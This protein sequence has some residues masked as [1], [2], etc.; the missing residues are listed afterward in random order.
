MTDF[1]I[2]LSTDETDLDVCLSKPTKEVAK[3]LRGM[4][5]KSVID[6]DTDHVLRVVYESAKAAIDEISADRFSTKAGNLLFIVI[7]VSA[8]R[9]IKDESRD[10]M[11]DAIEKEEAVE[12]HC[13]LDSKENQVTWRLY[14]AES[15]H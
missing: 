5:P 3:I 14:G 15:L 13:L 1:V 8:M 4:E 11:M 2:R 10:I 9:V 7:L 6:D 12:L